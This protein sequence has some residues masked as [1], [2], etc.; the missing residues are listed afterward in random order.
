VLENQPCRTQGR[1]H[2][3]WRGSITG[4]RRRA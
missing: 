4:E 1:H 2:F 3:Q